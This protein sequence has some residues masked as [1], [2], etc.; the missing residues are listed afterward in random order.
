MDKGTKQLIYLAYLG[1][2]IVVMCWWFSGAMVYNHE[3]GHCYQYYKYGCLHC[4]IVIG[5]GSS[6]TINELYGTPKEVCGYVWCREII[7][8]TYQ[9]RAEIWMGGIYFDTK[10]NLMLMAFPLISVFTSFFTSANL[11]FGNSTDIVEA[12]KFGYSRAKLN[13]LLVINLFF[14]IVSCILLWVLCEHFKALVK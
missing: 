10:A 9:E 6:I 8:P 12:V 1:L 13:I 7:N 2:T 5:N 3:A 4:N 14:F 11:I